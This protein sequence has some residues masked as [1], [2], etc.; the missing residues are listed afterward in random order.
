MRKL[1][2]KSE[3]PLDLR[4]TV[5]VSNEKLSALKAFCY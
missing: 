4:D 2:C 1:E 3:V 5:E